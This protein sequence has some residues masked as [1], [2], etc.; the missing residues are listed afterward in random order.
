MISYERYT[1]YR[2]AKNMKDGEVARKANIPPSTFSDWK[3]GRCAPKLE[4]MQKIADA[5]E[6]DY[7]ELVGPVGKFSSYNANNILHKETTATID[8]EIDPERLTKAMELFDAYTNAIPELR[9]AVDRLLHPK[10]D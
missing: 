8:I 4:K 10:A 2:D 7:Y 3:S 9:A 5:L 1:K 6:V